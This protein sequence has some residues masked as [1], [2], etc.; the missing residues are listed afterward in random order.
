MTRKPFHFKQFSIFH[1]RCSMKVGTDG[2]LLGAWATVEGAQSIL[3]I[4]TGT[5]MIAIMAAQ[6]T[7]GLSNIDGIEIDNDAYSQAQE[8]VNNSKWKELITVHHTSIQEFS[9]TCQKQYDLIISNPP[10]FLAGTQ[11]GSE[12]RNTARHATL[13]THSDLLR[14]V[15]KL[16][17]PDGKFSLILPLEEG[18]LFNEQAKVSGLFCTRLT[19][20]KPKKEKPYERLLIELSRQNLSIIE[21]ELTIQFDKRNNYTPEYYELTREFYTIME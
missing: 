21:N 19:K 9:I 10:F 12:K 5:G 18:Q 8:N 2:V 7:N 14:S 15:N 13:L 1:D 4:G 16:L 3:D 11:S 20:V 17:K 6:R